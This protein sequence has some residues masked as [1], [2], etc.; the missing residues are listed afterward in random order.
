MAENW[1]LNDAFVSIGAV[2][3]NLN[4][5]FCICNAGYHF[6]N[7]DAVQIIGGQNGA[8]FM[9][10]VSAKSVRG[11]DIVPGVRASNCSIEFPAFAA[12]APGLGSKGNKKW[13][14]AQ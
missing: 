1:R 8:N 3:G 6:A 9:S 13:P 2:V 4:P 10:S 5:L 7:G 11:R 14:I 12:S